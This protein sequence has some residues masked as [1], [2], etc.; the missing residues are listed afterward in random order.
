MNALGTLH[1][2]LQISNEGPSLLVYLGAVV[3]ACRNMNRATIPSVLTL[4]GVGILAA[5]TIGASVVQ[6]FLLESRPPADM[7]RQW[8][9]IGLVKSCGRAGGLG[10]LIAAIFVGRGQVHRTNGRYLVEDDEDE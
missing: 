9:I 6:A 3:L 4:V 1:L 5:T 2:F 10:F 8:L 7:A